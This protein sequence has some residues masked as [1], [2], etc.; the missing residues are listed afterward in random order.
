MPV[1]FVAI[2]KNDQGQ[3]THVRTNGGDV[4]SMEEA[5]NMA[6]TGEIDSLTDVH[7]D[8]TWEIRSAAGTGDYSEGYNLDGLPEF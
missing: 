4:V 7:A 6:K 8:G 2:R 3:I 5:A 1:K